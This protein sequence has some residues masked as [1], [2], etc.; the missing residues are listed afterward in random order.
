MKYIIWFLALSSSL[1]FAQGA[2][3][4]EIL[5]TQSGDNLT[6][7][8]DQN[9]Y[10]TP[11]RSPCGTTFDSVSSRSTSPSASRSCKIWRRAS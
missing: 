2:S 3:D 6:L 8:I 11:D 1:V 10:G 5:I 9:G 4:N 7:T